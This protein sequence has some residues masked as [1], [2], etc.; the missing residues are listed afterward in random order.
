MKIRKRDVLYILK[1][2]TSSGARPEV[3]IATTAKGE[4]TYSVRAQ[5]RNVREAADRALEEFRRV[6]GAVLRIKAEEKR[7]QDLEL[8]R[9]LKAEKT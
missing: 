7:Q 1:D 4:I 3:E 9:L 8:N 5:A 2:A 6:R